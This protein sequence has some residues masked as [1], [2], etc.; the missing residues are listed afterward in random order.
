MQ[1]TGYVLPPFVRWEQ[2]CWQGLHQGR[3]QALDLQAPA[4]HVNAHDALAWCQWAGRRL[5]TEAEW[6]CAAQAPEFAWG[7]VW[8][9]TASTFRPYPGFAPGPDA[10]YSQAGFDRAKVLR[11]GSAA[12][13]TRLKSARFRRFAEPASDQLFCGFRSCAL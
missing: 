11:G 5:P 8:E 4:V 3:W 6:T 13:R 7:Q 2:G 9:W 1:A 12:T 10:A